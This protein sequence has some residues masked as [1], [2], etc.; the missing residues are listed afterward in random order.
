MANAAVGADFGL[1]MPTESVARNTLTTNVTSTIDFVKQFLPLLSSNGR[2]VL[3]SAALG[4][5]NGQPQQ[6]KA[7][8]ND[9]NLTENEIIHMANDYIASVVKKDMGYYNLS[10][11]KTSKALLNSWARFILPYIYH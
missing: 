8:L 5:I 3:V 11:Y 1:K 9:P 7:K 10:A 6:L 4:A 2:V